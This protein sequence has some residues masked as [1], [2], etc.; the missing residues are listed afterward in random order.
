MTGEPEKTQSDP[1]WGSAKV[2]NRL[3][4]ETPSGRGLPPC[5]EGG[6]NGEGR[7]CEEL[8]E[9]WH[10]RSLMRGRDVDEIG[11]DQGRSHLRIRYGP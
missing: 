6:R 5:G 1:Y 9:R 10:A 8:I 4:L 11:R 7:V 2:L 3:P